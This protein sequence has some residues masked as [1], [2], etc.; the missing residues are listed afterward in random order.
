MFYGGINPK[1]NHSLTYI[2]TNNRMITPQNGFSSTKKNKKSVTFNSKVDV[3]N[4]ESFKE[5]NKIDEDVFNADY[6][7]RYNFPTDYNNGIKNIKKKDC[8]CTC[9]IC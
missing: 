8:D 1:N 9:N 3:V 5:F 2:N 7:Q 6:F 4:V